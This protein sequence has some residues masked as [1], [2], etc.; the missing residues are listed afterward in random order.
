MGQNLK[1][2]KMAKSTRISCRSENT[3]DLEAGSRIYAVD[4]KNRFGTV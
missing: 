4:K 3:N 2:D 1:I